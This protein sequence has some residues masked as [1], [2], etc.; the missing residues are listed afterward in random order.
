MEV[1]RRI[2][3]S[4]GGGFH[5]QEVKNYGSYVQPYHLSRY[6]SVGFALLGIGPAQDRILFVLNHYPEAARAKITLADASATELVALDSGVSIKLINGS[7]ELDLDRKS[8]SVFR[9]L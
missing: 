2:G 7:I 9:V 3:Q 1:D 5:R 8:A 6:D 4:L